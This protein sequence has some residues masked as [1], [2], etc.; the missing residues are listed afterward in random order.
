[1]RGSSYDWGPKLP[2]GTFKNQAKALRVVKALESKGLRVFFDYDAMAKHAS[3]TPRQGMNSAMAAN[4]DSAAAVVVCFSE[5]YEASNNCMKEL[6]YADAN[7]KYIY[8]VN[9]REQGAPSSQGELAFLRGDKLYSGNRTEAEFQGRAGFASLWEAMYTCPAIKALVDEE[10][11]RR[12]CGGEAAAG[13]AGAASAGASGGSA[14]AAA[15]ASASA[16]ASAAAGA[17][18]ALGFLGS[19]LGLGGAS[20]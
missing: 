9:S 17:A 5:T 3:I 15:S 11:G 20:K 1:M 14:A 7:N 13:A 16:S 18:S 12:S 6:R 8:Y 2:D 4:I 10:G 19:L